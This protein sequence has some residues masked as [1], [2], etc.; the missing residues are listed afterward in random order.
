MFST[1]TGSSLD[2]GGARSVTAPRSG[3]G[4]LDLP[5]TESPS[6]PVP[7]L[8]VTETTTRRTD[9]VNCRTQN[10]SAGEVYYLCLTK[11]LD[12]HKPGLPWE[13]GLDLSLVGG[14]GGFFPDEVS[15]KFAVHS[16]GTDRSGP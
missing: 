10:K 12:L 9:G 1:V 5:H 13:G 7:S 15:E 3:S 16:V 11:F 2:I 6:T 8:G 14:L 4:T